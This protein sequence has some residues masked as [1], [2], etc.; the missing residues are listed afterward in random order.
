MDYLEAKANFE[1]EMSKALRG[2]LDK[3]AFLASARD[4]IEIHHD[5]LAMTNGTSD[6]IS[7]L[8]E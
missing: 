4:L 8:S 7:S 5:I 2:E 3:D 6:D 1:Y